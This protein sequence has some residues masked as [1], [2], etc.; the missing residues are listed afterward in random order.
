MHELEKNNIK[1]KL[2]KWVE[3]AK[4]RNKWL[5]RTRHPYIRAVHARYVRANTE[6]MPGQT[7]V[8]RKSGGRGHHGSRLLQGRIHARGGAPQ[9]TKTTHLSLGWTKGR[10]ELVRAAPAGVLLSFL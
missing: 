1:K 6:K 4:N 9:T 5:G 2:I 10:G 8:A 3:L 7:G